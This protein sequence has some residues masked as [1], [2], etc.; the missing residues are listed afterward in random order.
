MSR[1]D[2]YTETESRFVV[3]QDWGVIFLSSFEGM[4]MFYIQSVVTAVQLC[5]YTKTHSIVHLKWVSFMGCKLYVN[6]T[7]KKKKR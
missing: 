5:K 3:V 6:K 1:K 7:V 4:G 2:K